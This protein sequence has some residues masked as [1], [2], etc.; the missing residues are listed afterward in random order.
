MDEPPVRY[1]MM[2]SNEWRT[3]ASWPPEDTRW[4]KLYL[5]SWE[6][7]TTE[8]FVPASAD[9][10]QKPDAFLQMPPTQTNTLQRLRYMTEPLAEDV[11][12]AGPAVLTLFAALDSDDT[13]W[14]VVLRDI[15]PD[16]SVMSVREGERAVPTDLKERELTRGWLKAS[17]RAVDPARS[18]PGR[19]W[20]PLS[21]E[22]QKKVVPGEINEYQIEILATANVFRRG[23]RIAIDIMSADLPTGV[24]GA[25]NAE[26]IPYHI[27]AAETVTHKI[28][29]D[30]ERPSHLLLPIVKA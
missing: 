29:H 5:R 19:P 15:G 23:H 22:T 12:M 26:Y 20:H 13:N 4:T 21:R 14:I 10:F 2:G 25:T 18:R 9:Q 8:P 3:A 1:W 30:P 6:R 16:V 17:H 11:A 27:C 28:Y 7:L 24:A